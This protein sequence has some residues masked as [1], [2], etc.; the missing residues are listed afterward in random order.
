MLSP[1]CLDSCAVL[2]IF[3][4]EGMCVASGKHTH[5]IALHHCWAAW[6]LH[7]G[8]TKLYVSYLRREECKLIFYEKSL[9][10]GQSLIKSFQ[11]SICIE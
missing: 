10:L 11:K 7:F 1:A 8:G 4:R 5:K 6:L 3:G 9:I 2:L